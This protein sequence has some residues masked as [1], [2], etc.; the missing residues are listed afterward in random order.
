MSEAFIDLLQ[1]VDEHLS[2]SNQAW[3]LGAG[4][5]KDAGLPLMKDLTAQVFKKA[6]GKPHAVVLTALRDEL[7]QTAHIEHMLS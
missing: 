5:S 3:L 1:Q 6:M 2:Q 7:P 4:I